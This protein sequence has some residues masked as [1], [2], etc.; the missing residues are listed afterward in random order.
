MDYWL[1][2]LKDGL[3]YGLNGVLDRLCRLRGLKVFVRAR[4]VDVRK[5]AHAHARGFCSMCEDVA[6]SH[7]LGAAADAAGCRRISVA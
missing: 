6:A 5:R 3:F 1:V 4:C 2:W 7:E